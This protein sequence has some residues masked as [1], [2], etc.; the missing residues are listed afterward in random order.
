MPEAVTPAHVVEQ[1][2]PAS[3]TVVGACG[4]LKKLEEL[5]RGR[6]AWRLFFFELQVL[7]RATVKCARIGPTYPPQVSTLRAE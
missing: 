3:D 4:W 1:H 2:A 6:W 5:A 7:A